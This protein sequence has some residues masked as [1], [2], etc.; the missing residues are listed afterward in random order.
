M[1]GEVKDP[2]K[3]EHPCVVPFSKLPV[4]QQAKDFLFRQVVHSLK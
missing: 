3:K 2:A 4:E 1:Y